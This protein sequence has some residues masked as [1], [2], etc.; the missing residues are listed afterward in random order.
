MRTDANGQGIAMLGIEMPMETWLTGWPSRLT[1]EIA[2]KREK[3][4]RAVAYERKDGSGVMFRVR[5][6]RSDKSPHWSGEIVL[7][8]VS[9]ELAAW[10][11][12]SKKSGQPYLSCRI[13]KKVGI[14]Q[15]EWNKK[16]EQRQW[17][18]VATARTMD[19]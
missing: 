8:G 13:Q 6:R 4:E 5:E 15:E 11:N 10:D 9:Y 1:R 17:D 3:T 14:S 16:K 12:T 18:R 7:N 19:D 2:T